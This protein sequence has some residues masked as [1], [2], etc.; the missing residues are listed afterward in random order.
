MATQLFEILLLLLKDGNTVGTRS[1]D[2]IYC[3]FGLCFLEQLMV[4]AC[5]LVRVNNSCEG[6]GIDFC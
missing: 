5:Q 6:E 1:Y 3:F 2:S 4:F